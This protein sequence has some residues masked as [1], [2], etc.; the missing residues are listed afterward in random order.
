MRRWVEHMQRGGAT[1]SI[2]LVLLT[3]ALSQ[4]RLEYTL[5]IPPVEAQRFQNVKH[6]R[7]A[8]L[9]PFDYTREARTKNLW[10]A[11]GVTQYYTYLMRTLSPAS[12]RE[13]CLC[14]ATATEQLA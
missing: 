3:L 4:P 6:F 1:L 7:P 14:P 2:M 8:V 12:R 13:S 10:F 11:E 5:T 9:G